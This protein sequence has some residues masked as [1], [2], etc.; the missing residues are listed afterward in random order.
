MNICPWIWHAR[1]QVGSRLAVASRA[2]IRRPR[3]DDDP[4]GAIATF[5]RKASTSLFSVRLGTLPFFDAI[6]EFERLRGRYALNIGRASPN[7]N[8]Q[9]ARSTRAWIASLS[10]MIDENPLHVVGGHTR[11]RPGNGRAYAPIITEPSPERRVAR[12][13]DSSTCATIARHETV[14]ISVPEHTGVQMTEHR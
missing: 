7:E 12:R 13:A 2:K 5:L 6:S 14:F 3:P 11:L 10:S 8:M 4:K 9:G 1:S